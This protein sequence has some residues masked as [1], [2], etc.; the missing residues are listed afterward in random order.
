M[1]LSSTL[2]NKSKL[3]ITKTIEGRKNVK[4]EKKPKETS[5]KYII[6]NSINKKINTINNPNYKRISGSSNRCIF[7]NKQKPMII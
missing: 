2:R 4:I 3:Y 5:N 6:D 1:N 7:V